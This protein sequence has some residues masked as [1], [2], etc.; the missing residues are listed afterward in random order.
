MQEVLTPVQSFCKQAS[1]QEIMDFFSAV[2][3]MTSEF[4][5][6]M[7]ASLDMKAK[8]NDAESKR[9]ADFGKANGL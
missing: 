1:H 7:Q 4:L 6:E 5:K 9:I 3:S 8:D 2:K